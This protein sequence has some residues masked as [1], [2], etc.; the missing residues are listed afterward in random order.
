M[1]SIFK[2]PI[3]ITDVFTLELPKKAKI[4]TF[5]TQHEQPCIWALVDS[6]AEKETRHFKLYGTGHPV[7]SIYSLK[8]IGTTQMADG[9]LVWHLFEKEV[10]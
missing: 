4:L 6:N 2:Y 5:Q 1:K 3:P 9:G 10:I 7:E 8:Y